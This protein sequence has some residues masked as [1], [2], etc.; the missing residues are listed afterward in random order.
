VQILE[1][2]GVL[3]AFVCGECGALVVDKVP[4]DGFH[5]SVETPLPSPEA[6]HRA[7]VPHIAGASAGNP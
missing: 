6:G 5:D 7:R 2:G 3:P 4:H 1:G